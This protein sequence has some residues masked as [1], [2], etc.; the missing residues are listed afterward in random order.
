MLGYSK[1]FLRRTNNLME[2]LA[3]YEGLRIIKVHQLTPAEINTDSQEIIKILKKNHDLYDG[4][5][6]N[7]YLDGATRIVGELA[8]GV[9]SHCGD[10]V[11]LAVF[12]FRIGIVILALHDASDV[13]MEAAKLF[14][15]SW[16]ELGASVLFGCFVVSWLVLSLFFFPFWVIQS[17]RYYLCEVL[18]LSDP[19]DTMLYYFFNTMLLTLLVFHIYWSVLICSIIR[20]Q[21][22]NR[23]QIGEDI[24]SSKHF[25]VILNLQVMVPFR[26]ELFLTK[27]LSL[28]ESGE[29]LMTRMDNDVERVLRV[30]FVTGLFEHSF[31]DRS[32]IDLVG[33]K[34]HRDL[35]REAV[36]KSLVLLKNGKDPKK[37]FLP[38]DK[39]TKK[40]LVARTHANDLG[41]QCRGWTATWIGLSGRITVASVGLA[42]LLVPHDTVLRVFP[43]LIIEG[44]AIQ[45][46]H[47]AFNSA[48]KDFEGN[49]IFSNSL[50]DRWGGGSVLENVAETIVSLVTEKGVQN[51][52]RDEENDEEID[53]T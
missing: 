28:V 21:L 23:G 34:A 49:I 38:L 35:S 12:F 14:K 42:V 17:S 19:Y 25:S 27:L 26:Y 29:I 15:Y 31:T 39:T 51:E 22:N 46:G 11:S 37:P 32:L 24:R 43:R 5:R 18:K 41:Y 45:L 52:E 44:P 2:L 1:S 10:P 4:E 6:L 13:F 53:L 47:W 30:K 3:L 7:L 33:C 40:I 8:I 20:R 9:C 50:L 48:I 36:R 16:K